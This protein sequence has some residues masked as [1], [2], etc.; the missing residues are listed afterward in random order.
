MN[1]VSRAHPGS[2]GRSRGPSRMLGRLRAWID[3]PMPVVRLEIL[4]VLAP[5]AVLGFMSGRLIHADEW[6][7]DAGFRVPHL[8]GDPSQP[9]Y[10]PALPSGAAWL[11]VVVMVASGLSLSVGWKSRASAFVFAGTLSFIA[12]S[13]RLAAFTVSKISPVIMVAIACGPAG[14]R[15]GLEAWL[16]RGRGEPPAPAIAPLPPIRFLQ[17][18]LV[19]F[20]SASGIAKAGGDWLT[21]PLVL[22]SHLHDTYQTPFA[23]FMAKTLPGSLWTP[24]QYAVLTFEAFAPLWFGLSGT[25]LLALAFGLGMHAMIGLMFGPVVW[26]ALLMMTLLAGCFLPARWLAPLEAA[27]T[28]LTGH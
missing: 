17:L 6:I 9:L 19:T 5:L 14:T 25:R 28:R 23:F 3:Q 12:L 11:V 16:R 2:S 20:Y 18:M 15:L 10:L 1:R 4:R 27:A 7:G 24:L 13:D 22:W 8:Q 21:T 26:F